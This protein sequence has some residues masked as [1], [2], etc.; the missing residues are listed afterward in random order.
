MQSKAV[1][2]DR[3]GVINPSYG[4]RPP[5]HPQEFTLFPGVG[6]A[7]HKLNMANYKVFVVTNQGG[8]GLGYM[9]KEQLD[10]I[11]Q[12]M[13]NQIQALDGKI[14]Q[15]MA[16]I[17]KPW[18]GC[19]C[20]KPKPGMITSLAKQYTINLA[21]SYIVGDRDVDIQAGQAGGTK[22]ILIC[23]SNQGNIEA[24]YVVGDLT[25]AVE[26]ILAN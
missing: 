14:D 10:K 16:C 17:H 22:T 15:V 24:D 18:V 1:F 23:D 8:V 9:S 26:I 19:A 13:I 20:R 21:D 5:N 12:D 11:H 3:D 7:I 2:L 25:Q 6:E 4:T